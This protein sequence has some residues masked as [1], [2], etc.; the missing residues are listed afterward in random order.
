MIFE[1]DN[2]DDSKF[3]IFL[4]CTLTGGIFKA[5]KQPEQIGGIPFLAL[6]C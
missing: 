2:I 3:N 6:G 5:V 1:V 4:N